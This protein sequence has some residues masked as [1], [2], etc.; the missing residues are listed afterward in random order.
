MRR[1]LPLRL[2]SRFSPK[3]TASLGAP[4]DNMRGHIPVEIVRLSAASLAP[5]ADQLLPVYHAAFAE[6]PY[7]RDFAQTNAF[8]GALSNHMLRRDFRCC[9]ARE[10]TG[11]AITGFTYGYS[12]EPGQWW[13]DVVGAAMEPA[14]VGTWL[15]GSFEFVELAV[16]PQ[17]QGRGT[18]GR[19]HDAL[20]DGLA[21]RTAV[22][23]T[24]QHETAA[25][26]LYRKRGWVELVRDLAFPGVADPY[27]VMGIDLAQRSGRAAP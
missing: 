24:I 6:P 21:N 2:S 26:Q 1:L 15:N 20:L 14:A 5:L 8:A 22:L 9:L 11:G 17:A 23:S 18:G 12:G 27:L 19:L 10:S 25:L 4:K 3:A 13:H 16:L 7:N